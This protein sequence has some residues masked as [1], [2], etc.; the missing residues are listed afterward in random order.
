MNPR[1]QFDMNCNAF[2]SVCNYFI[3]DCICLNLLINHVHIFRSIGCTQEDRQP[4]QSRAAAPAAPSSPRLFWLVA[5][6]CPHRST[7]QQQLPPLLQ[8]LPHS[9]RLTQQV[10]HRTEYMLLLHLFHLNWA[11]NNHRSSSSKAGRRAKDLP[12]AL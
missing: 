3:L 7:P 1:T 5:Y 2:F 8:Q 12:L 10:L 11:H 6:G 9:Q 4:P